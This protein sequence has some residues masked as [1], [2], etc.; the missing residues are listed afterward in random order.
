ML[1]PGTPFLQ[2]PNSPDRPEAT[3]LSGSGS[4]GERGVETQGGGAA[5]VLQ[6]MSTHAWLRHEEMEYVTG[7]G[8]GKRHSTCTAGKVSL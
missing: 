4:T 6:R 8:A 5:E 2:H 1:I 3:V 7:V